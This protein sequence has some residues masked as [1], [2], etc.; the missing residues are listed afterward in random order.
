MCSP[1]SLKR[2]FFRDLPLTA[3]GPSRLFPVEPVAATQLDDA[4]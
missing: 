2:R 3:A 4:P 1:A